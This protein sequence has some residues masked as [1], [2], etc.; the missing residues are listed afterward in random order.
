MG[1]VAAAQM[2][3]I[4]GR[5]YWAVVTVEAVAPEMVASS[6]ASRGDP[7]APAVSGC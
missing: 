3:R 4:T 2:P 6:R 1:T 7:P 5:E